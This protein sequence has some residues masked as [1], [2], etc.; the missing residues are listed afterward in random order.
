M[1]VLPVL[2]D[3]VLVITAAV[4]F[5]VALTDFN[6]FKIRNE[7]IL[8]LVG[9][10]LL[11]AFLSGRWV[12]LHWNLALAVFMFLIM[13]FFYAQNWM[14]GGDVKILT[15]GFLWVGLSC[16]LAFAILLLVFAMIH[17]AAAK[18]GWVNTQQAGDRQRIPFAPSVAGA[19][20]VVFMSG[21]LKPMSLLTQL[22]DDV[23]PAMSRSIETPGHNLP[24]RASL[25]VD[26]APA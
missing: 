10:F 12:N 18:F 8:I 13:L 15:V 3:V 2:S 20:I 19:L 23:R 4:L 14:G 22:S 6:E 1:S 21:C 16:A 11:H 25:T 26:T 5:Y 17:V 9:L 7:P 24:V